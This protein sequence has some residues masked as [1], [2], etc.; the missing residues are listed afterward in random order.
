MSQG[1][2]CPDFSQGQT[3]LRAGNVSGPG[4]SQGSWQDMSRAGSVLR[5]EESKSL[6]AEVSCSR[7]WFAAGSVLELNFQ[8]LYSISKSWAPLLGTTSLHTAHTF[9]HEAMIIHD[10]YYP[11]VIPL[12]THSGIYGTVAQ[13]VLPVTSLHTIV[14]TSKIQRK[15]FRIRISINYVS[16]V[17]NFY[18]GD[19]CTFVLQSDGKPDRKL[20][21]YVDLVTG[22]LSS[23]LSQKSTIMQRLKV[24]GYRQ[25]HG[26]WTRRLNP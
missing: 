11:S 5:P 6:G 1:R 21:F 12:F 17:E 14:V 4:L 13:D 15:S 19:Q 7:T 26:L 10:F 18:F 22:C 3:C 16:R 9:V 20:L 25:V 24:L 8:S 23:R 2:I